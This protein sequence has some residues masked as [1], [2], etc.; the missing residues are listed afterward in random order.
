LFIDGGLLNLGG[1]IHLSTKTKIMSDTIQAEKWENPDKSKLPGSLNI[2][3]ILTFIGCGVALIFIFGAKKMMELGIKMAD[4]PEVAEKMSDKELADM[5]KLKS[6]YDL[7]TSNWI[8]YLIPSLIGVALCFFGA[9]QMRKLKK[10][11]FYTYVIG[12]ILPIVG[13]AIVLGFSNQFSN[14]SSY[15]FGLAV[16]ILF[17]FLYSRNLKYLS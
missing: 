9:L 6:M 12:Q 3:T 15:I 14:T 5:E 7:M 17:I 4:R 8:A 1:K 16:P 2:L 11:G 13:S 10:Q